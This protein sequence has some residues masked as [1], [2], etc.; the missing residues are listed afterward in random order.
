PEIPATFWR[1]RTVSVT[2]RPLQQPLELELVAQ[3]DHVPARLGERVAVERGEDEAATLV[4]AQHAEVVPRRGRRSRRGPTGDVSVFAK[5][6]WVSP[7]AARRALR[8]IRGRRRRADGPPSE[9]VGVAED[10]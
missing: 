7:N 5:R 2:A 4:E 6:R 9:E 10:E 3:R 8:P 1:W